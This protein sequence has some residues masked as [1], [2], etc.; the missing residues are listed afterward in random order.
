MTQAPSPGGDPPTTQDNHTQEEEPALV[1]PAC[2]QCLSPHL[3]HPLSP[4]PSLP[5][6]TACPD[7]ATTALPLQVRKGQGCGLNIAQLPGYKGK[8]SHPLHPLLHVGH[9]S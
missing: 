4:R 2:L 7:V 8:D 3:Q 1:P 5:S 9:L 6:P